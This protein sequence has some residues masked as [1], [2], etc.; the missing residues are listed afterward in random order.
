MDLGFVYFESAHTLL[1]TLVL[2]L[3]F[4]CHA[5]DPKAKCMSRLTFVNFY[6]LHGMGG[7]TVCL[8]KFVTLLR[9]CEAQYS[10]A[11]AHLHYLPPNTHK[12]RDSQIFTAS[13]VTTL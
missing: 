4:N 13:E 10:I 12:L 8:F 1:V 7:I 9:G 3:I 5:R 2:K 6:R 11:L